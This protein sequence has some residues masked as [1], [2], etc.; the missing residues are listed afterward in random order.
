MSK[1]MAKHD[2]RRYLTCRDHGH[3]WGAQLAWGD[4]SRYGTHKC[5]RCGIWGSPKIGGDQ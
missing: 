4:P 2:L 5:K 3:D 1:E